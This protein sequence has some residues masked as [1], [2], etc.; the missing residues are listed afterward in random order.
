VVTA[1]EVVDVREGEELLLVVDSVD[2]SDVV[3]SLVVEVD[4]VVAVSDDVV[5]EVVSEVVS[6]VVELVVSVVVDVVDVVVSVVS[7]VDVADVV[8]ASMVVS[9]ELSSK[10]PDQVGVRK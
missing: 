1:D 2:D 5:E 4:E 6:D 8:L 3:D 10:G 9:P 7:V